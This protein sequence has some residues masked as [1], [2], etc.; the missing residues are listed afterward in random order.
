MIGL[1][2]IDSGSN[3]GIPAGYVSNLER[4]LAETEAALFVALTSLRTTSEAVSSAD[5]AIR[6]CLASFKEQTDNETR[7]EK[8]NTWYRLPL[9]SRREQNEWW[10]TMRKKVVVNSF[11][12]RDPDLHSAAHLGSST[13]S[14]RNGNLGLSSPYVQED[15]LTSTLR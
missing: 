1:K 10:A 11:S 4:R 5:E 3:R 12:E 8:L 6:E 9:G 14:R 13:E 7:Q 15:V 2:C